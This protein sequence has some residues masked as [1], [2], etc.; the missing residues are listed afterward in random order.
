MTV[1]TTE[2]MRDS[3]IKQVKAKITTEKVYKKK[4]LWKVIAKNEIRVRT[5]GFRKHRV[6]TFVVIY[7]ILLLW[8]FIG[9]P[10]L[11][12]LFVPTLA[13]QYASIF[14]PVVAIIIESV[15]MALF[16]MLVMYPLNNVYR[17]SETGFKESLLATPVR[18]ND[19]FLGE[20][21]GKF[22]IYSMAVL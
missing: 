11:F 14:K 12:D 5:S 6:K 22:P 4:S 16:L 15:M 20:F 17:E 1:L 21:L 3:S 10:F 13:I 8:A 18:P 2:K 19:I 9:A 7:A